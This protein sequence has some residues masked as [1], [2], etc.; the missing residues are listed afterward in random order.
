MH[1]QAQS[2]TLPAERTKPHGR[3]RAKSQDRRNLR[4]RA[5]RLDAWL[6]RIQSEGLATIRR[7][8][9]ALL[10]SCKREGCTEEFEPKP[11]KLFCNSPACRKALGASR[12]KA[13]YRGHKEARLQYSREHRD[14]D[15]ASRRARYPRRRRKILRL[16]RE[17]YAGHRPQ[18]QEAQRRR[19][20][21]DR[22][23]IAE[24]ERIQ[25]EL[26]GAE[27]KLSESRESLRKQETIVKELRGKLGR[28]ATVD[29]DRKRFGPRIRELRDQKKSWVALT[30]IM[31][32][33]SG[34][35]RS[36]SSWRHLRDT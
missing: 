4:S 1:S 35:H 5:R 19:Y 20:A 30:I 31:N 34:Q 22:E 17:K 15:N 18:I 10:Q 16:N 24:A 32:Y 6:K 36:V 28:P 29:H 33:E 12:A 8:G 23:K 21:R 2:S 26:R 13:Y 11:A 9:D 7:A 25:A 3:S 27:A 14:R